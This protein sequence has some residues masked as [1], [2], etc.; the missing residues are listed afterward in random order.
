MNWN[1]CRRKFS[2]PN[3]RFYPRAWLQEPRKTT[4]ISRDRLCCG[5]DKNREPPYTSRKCYFSSQ[6]LSFMSCSLRYNPYPKNVTMRLRRSHVS[7]LVCDSTRSILPHLHKRTTGSRIE[8]VT[9]TN[10]QILKWVQE[11]D[12]KPWP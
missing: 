9:R 12:V 10:S 7:E 6:P 5:W 11:S 3:F 1:G 8:T 4:N 2:W